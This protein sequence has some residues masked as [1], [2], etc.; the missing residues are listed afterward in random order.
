MLA[1]AIEEEGIPTVSL[2]SALDITS[3]VKP[4]R[5]FFINYPL[6]NTTG[7]P[8]DRKDQLDIIKTAL[9][10]AKLIK[11]PGA[12]IRLPN[13]WYEHGGDWETE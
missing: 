6:G 13:K 10:K 3:L 12:I 9:S 5:S 8:L 2:T 4:P 7:K 1:R 11:E